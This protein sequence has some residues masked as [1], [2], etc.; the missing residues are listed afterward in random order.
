MLRF[1]EKL[2]DTPLD[3]IEK[4]YGAWKC[5]EPRRKL[6]TMGAKW[7]RPGG[8]SPSARAREEDGGVDNKS[9]IKIVAQKSKSNSK[10]GISTANVGQDRRIIIG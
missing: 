4:P 3:K 6:H 1:C 2:F 8:I 9:V 10:S 5:A 7:L